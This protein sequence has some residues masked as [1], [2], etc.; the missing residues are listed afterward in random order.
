MYTKRFEITM[1]TIAILLYIFY[2]TAFIIN[3]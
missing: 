2:V 3:F 1:K